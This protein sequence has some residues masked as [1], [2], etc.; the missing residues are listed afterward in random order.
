MARRSVTSIY[1]AHSVLKLGISRNRDVPAERHDREFNASI[2]ASLKSIRK[3]IQKTDQLPGRYR[4]I[5]V[6]ERVQHAYDILVDMRMRVK[7]ERE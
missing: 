3:S 2:Y 6:R 1:T 7:E 5:T 4:V